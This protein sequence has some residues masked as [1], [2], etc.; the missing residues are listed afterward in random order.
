MVASHVSLADAQTVHILVS[1][2]L[3]LT[4]AVCFLL[5][6]L[7]CCPHQGHTPDLLG[8]SAVHTHCLTSGL[9]RTGYAVSPSCV[10]EHPPLCR[11]GLAVLT[12]SLNSRQAGG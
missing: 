12:T 1:P 4:S 2:S 5:S 3:P 8:L 6:L 9:G 11:E 7:R 10:S